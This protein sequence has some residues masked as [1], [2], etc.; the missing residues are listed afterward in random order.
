M[1]HTLASLLVLGVAL[2][3]GCESPDLREA[4]AADENVA[5]HRVL[6]VGDTAFGENY[7]EEY[8][9]AGYENIL[10]TKGY[11]HCMQAV[12]PMLASADFVVANLETP[13]TNLRESPHAAIKGYIHWDDVAEAPAAL[14]RHHVGAVSLA[15]NHTLDFGIPGLVETMAALERVGIEWFGAGNNEEE[16][17]KPFRYDMT[18]GKHQLRLV[19]AA[20]FEYNRFYSED[21]EFFARG[22]TAGCNAWP[23]ERA[24]AHIAELRRAAPDAFIIAFPHF[25]KNYWLRTRRQ[26]AEAYAM[27]D[28]GAD[29][30]LGHG[31]HH[32]Q[33]ME[34]Y[35][36]RWIVY[37]LGNF[38]FN[39]QGQYQETGKDPFSLVA[40]L[41]FVDA[42]PAGALRLRLY[43]ILCDNLATDYQPRPVSEDEFGVVQEFLLR[44][45]RIPH[46]LRDDMTRG[47]DNVGRF[48]EIDVTPDR[49]GG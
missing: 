8:A 42:A 4:A 49:A 3:P 16:A 15:N 36:G 18:A 14:K 1:R 7:Q 43:P 44:Y 35:R 11:D 41:D 17:K 47:R 29:L 30:V 21:L 38:V 24:A 39:T 40:R 25:G 37:S 2:F 32:M 20:G 9:R 33:E 45:S 13:I 48:F 22:D 31:A 28:A 23:A 12:A 46:H 27:I 19:V 6:F 10:E 34:R 26:R 5:R